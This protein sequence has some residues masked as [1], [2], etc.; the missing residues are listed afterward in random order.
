MML[1]AGSAKIVLKTFDVVLSKICAGLHLDKN[2]DIALMRI[3]DA[4][5]IADRYIDR[6]SGSN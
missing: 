2:Q 1:N 3:L 6:I 4:V 5:G